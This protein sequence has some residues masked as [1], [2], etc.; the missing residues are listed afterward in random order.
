MNPTAPIRAVDPASGEP[1]GEAF[2]AATPGEIENTLARAAA[3][4]DEH[5]EPDVSK[6]I[7]LLRRYADL[8]QA[9][10]NELTAIASRETGL[11]AEPRLGEVE[12]NRTVNQLRLA[13]DAVADGSWALPTIETRLNIRSLHA[14]IGPVLIL[15]PANFPFAYNALAGGD[16]ASAVGVGCP[17]IA[18]G[19]P[20]HP[21]TSA[22]LWQL[23]QQAMSETHTPDGVVQF[24]A[25]CANDDVIRMVRDPRIAAVGFTGSRG[26]GLAIK[27]AADEA[28]KPSFL[29]MSSLNPT[30]ILPG[31]LAENFEKVVGDYVASELM[32]VGQMCTNPG[33]VLMMAGD[34]TEK[35]IEAVAAR[36]LQT[37]IGPLLHEG[38]LRSLVDAFDS[39][40][41]AGAKRVVG[42]SRGAGGFRFQPSLLRVS[43]SRF[44]EEPAAFMREMF[45]PAALVVVASDLDQLLDI[46]RTLEGNLCGSIYSSTGSSEDEAYERI[47][48]ILR[49]K[50]GRLLN[51]KMST[52][53]AVVPAMSHGGPFPATGHPG[54][55]AVGFPASL[56]RFTMLQC[57]DAVREHRLPK[58][59]RNENP[60]RT[61]R[62]V[63][64]QWTREPVTV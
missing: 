39:V 5:G 33:L 11:P 22:L 57:F 45:G 37:P 8:I 34:L 40:E 17:V 9:S 29:E 31:A 28:G 44:L 64:G 59:L 52:G 38:I 43:G 18:K 4:W 48:R 2:P 6:R 58:L 35:F 13:A 16:F 60:G 62:I 7:A 61:M 55:T 1:F 21:N 20:A 12:I 47:A 19:H 32:S 53:V 10:R 54:F 63:D 50:V 27:R 25:H 14:A 3:F 42:G 23:L 49:P 46:L 36:F 24:V 56:R 41:R 26:A 15:G 51:D 30:V